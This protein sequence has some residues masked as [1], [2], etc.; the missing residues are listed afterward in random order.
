MNRVDVVHSDRPVIIGSGIAGLSTALGLDGST[1]ITASVVGSGSSGYAQGGMAAAIAPTDD[2]SQHAADTRRVGAAIVD[3]AIADLVTRAAA[4]QIDW[5]VD[6]GARFDRTADGAIILGREA[7]HSAPRIVH[8][9]GDA[10]GLEIMRVLRSAVALRPDIEIVSETTLVDL[11]RAGDRIVGVLTVDRTGTPRVYTGPAVV[12]ATGGIGGV[13]RRSTNPAVVTGAGLASAARHGA[14]LADLEFVQFHPTAFASPDHPAPL[15]TEALRGEGAVLVNDRG[16][17]FMADVHPDAELAPRDV[18]AR[19][20]WAQIQD[21]HSVAIDATKAVGSAMP[22]RFPT[23][24]ELAREMGIDPAVEPIPV[25]PAEHFHMGG[26]ATDAAGRT[27]LDGLFAVGEVASTGLHGANRL[28]SNSLL[29]GAVMGHRC[30]AALTEMPTPPIADPLLVPAGAVERASASDGHLATVQSIAW[31]GVGIVR[32]GE[33][34]AQALA[35]LDGLTERTSDAATVVRVIADAAFRRRESR[36]AH[37]RADFPTIDEDQ[38]HR[39]F[40]VPT[41][42][43]MGRLDTAQL[44]AAR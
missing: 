4:S 16:E 1:V 28:A 2:P 15:V 38:R 10:T 42:V 26:V 40:T 23:V 32:S 20:V 43:E 33:G 5:L 6:L 17:R 41:P 25:A 8:A 27:S 34:L 39:S 21:G 36:G 3:E 44:T 37:Y 7:G 35:T 30:A 19:A 11:V 18:V 22:Q 9:G 13:Y 24:C 12:L 31:D 14:R 29:E